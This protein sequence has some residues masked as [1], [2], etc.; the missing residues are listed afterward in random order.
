MAAVKALNTDST[1][2]LIKARLCVAVINSLKAGLETLNSVNDLPRLGVLSH[3]GMMRETSF[4]DLKIQ[5][6]FLHTTI[7]PP[8]VE[9]IRMRISH[10]DLGVLACL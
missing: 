8:W 5:L 3:L 9:G 4:R 6:I 7:A 10:L 1:P 2:A